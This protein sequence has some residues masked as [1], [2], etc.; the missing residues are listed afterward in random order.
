MWTSNKNYPYKALEC[1]SL[2]FSSFK[3]MIARWKIS[4][5]KESAFLEFDLSNTSSL[6]SKLFKNMKIAE[7]DQSTRKVPLFNQESMFTNNWW[8]PERSSPIA[9]FLLFTIFLF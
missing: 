3:I 4:E 6:S 2:A 9:T 1:I 5:R 7:M 8:L